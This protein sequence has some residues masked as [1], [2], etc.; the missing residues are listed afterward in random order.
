MSNHNLLLFC[1]IC[2]LC[3]CNPD[4]QL[5]KELDTAVFKIDALQNQLDNN[6]FIHP[7]TMVHIVYL[8]LKDDLSEEDQ[9][10]LISSF[11]GLKSIQ[12]VKHFSIGDYKDVADKRAMSNYELCL[13]MSFDSKKAYDSYQ[14]DPAHLALKKSLDEYL[15][16]PPITYDYTV[17]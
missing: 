13:Q 9:S 8:N 10:T 7:G 4:A 3:S 16:A 12:G 15:E 11:K 2:A 6:I 5:R 17:R 14:E 1:L